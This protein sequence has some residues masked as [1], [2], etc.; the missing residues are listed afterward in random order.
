[1]D[2]VDRHASRLGQANRVTTRQIDGADR[3]GLIRWQAINQREEAL[4]DLAP[5]RRRHSGLDIQRLRVP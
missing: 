1:M 4:A 5:V 3:L 2:G